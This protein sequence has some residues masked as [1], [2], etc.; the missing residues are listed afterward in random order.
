MVSFLKCAVSQYL[1]VLTVCRLC[2]D[3][4]LTV[5]WSCVDCGLYSKSHAFSITV[6]TKCSTVDGKYFAS[7][8]K[9][10]QWRCGCPT[11][12]PPSSSEFN[13]ERM[14]PPGETRVWVTESI[15]CP[16]GNVNCCSLEILVS[17]RMCVLKYQSLPFN[18]NPQFQITEN[19]HRSS[20]PEGPL[21]SLEKMW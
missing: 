11:C 2:V 5:C 12:F 19:A 4:V 17:R 18:N 10:T 16:N 9:K 7:W 6:L 20:H 15:S 13:V 14:P 21:A 8:V 1:P 3:C